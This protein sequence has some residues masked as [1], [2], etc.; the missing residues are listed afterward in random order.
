MLGRRCE[1]ERDRP[2]KTEVTEDRF[3][4]LGHSGGIRLPNALMPPLMNNHGNYVGSLANV[5]RYLSQRAEALGVEIYPGFAAA[6][7]PAK[8]GMLS[9]YLGV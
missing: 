1:H 4:M 8:M 3:Y 2:L 6:E 5:T 7:L 9:E